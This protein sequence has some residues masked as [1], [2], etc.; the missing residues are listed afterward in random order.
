MSSTSFTFDLADVHFTL[1]DQLDLPGRLAKTERYSDFD[2][3]IY[4]ATIGEA[5]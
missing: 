4:E 3:D 1:F 5:H 2:R